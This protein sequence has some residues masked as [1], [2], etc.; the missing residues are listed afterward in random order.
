VKSEE[1]SEKNLLK[2]DMSKTVVIRWPHRAYLNIPPPVFNGD[3]TRRGVLMSLGY[4]EGF[5]LEEFADEDTK[6]E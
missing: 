4:R 6:T 1:D 2:W 5:V 3:D